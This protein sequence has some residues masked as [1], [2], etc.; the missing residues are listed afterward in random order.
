MENKKIRIALAGNPNSGKTT[1]FNALT[2]ARQKTGNYAGVTVEKKEGFKKYKGFDLIIND[3]PGIYSLTAYSLDEVVARDFILE[4]KPDVIVDVLDST[5]IERNLFLCLQ[6]QELGLPVVAALNISDQAEARGIEIHSEKL[7][8]LLGIPMV[9][10][11]GSKNEGL[12]ALLD[13]VLE[14]VKNCGSFQKK[15]SYGYELEIEIEKCAQVIL[16]DPEFAKKYPMRWL[17]IKLLEKDSHA[18]KKI[19]ESGK[20]EEIKKC[21][22]ESISRIENHFGRDSEI[23]LS[24]QRYAYVHGACKEAVQKKN[25]DNIFITEKVD[26]LLLNRVLALPIF[27]FILWGIF[28]AT[29]S[30]GEYPMQLLEG[31]FS[32]ISSFLLNH[33]EENLLR[34]VVVDGI[35]GGLGGV[36]SFVPLIILLFLFISLLEDSG[37]MSRAAF[38]MDKYLHYFGLHGQSFLP[39]LIGFGCSVPAIMAT[40]TLKNPRDRIITILVIPFMTCGAKLPVHILLAGTFFPENAGNMVFLIYIT[41]VALALVSAKIFR[42]TVLKGNETPFV[43]ELPPYRVPT[44]KGIFWHIWDKT[45]LYLKKAGTVLLAASILIWAMI[46]FPR[47]QADEKKYES[48]ALNYQSNEIDREIIKKDLLEQLDDNF[49]LENRGKDEVQ[50]I[51]EL[52]EKVKSGTSTVDQIIEEVIQ[53]KTDQYIEV[54]KAEESLSNSFAGKIGKIMEPFF[55]PLGFDWKVSISAI[56]GFAAKEV[57]V[58]TLGVLYK[59]GSEEN[60]ESESLRTALKKDVSF[61]SLTAICLMLF[62]LIIAPC[63]AAMATIKA[64]I[65]WKWLGFYVVFSIAL[66]WLAVFGVYRIGKLLI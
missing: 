45:G 44:L 10:T 46:T 40:R 4:E 63:L 11:I 35:I 3:L 16:S 20:A 65:G 7:S 21:L 41:G 32:G 23:A 36:L 33:M 24:E 51:N 26:K 50:R 62:T 18:V 58:S 31:F 28:Q 59:V 53:N 48:L 38:I 2:G 12:E 43:M 25:K 14:T 9:K 6:F 64:E 22:A 34:S 52:K 30:L 54:L 15:I 49:S 60:E 13:A 5:N 19:E 56:T 39:M 8:E 61:N 27:I 66:S 57:I 17:A 1:L 47:T 55:S 37:Y 29:F 42:K